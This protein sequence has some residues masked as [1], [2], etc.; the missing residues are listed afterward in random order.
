M[1]DADLY[2]TLL[3]KTLM[4]WP[5]FE[6]ER[7]AARK[8]A[9]TEPLIAKEICKWA[10]CCNSKA[11]ASSQLQQRETMIDPRRMENIRMCLADVVRRNVPGDVIETG[12][13]RGGS[14]IFMR[15][16]LRALSDSSRTVWLA[17]SFC[18]LPKPD[19]ARYPRDEGDVHWNVAGL[20]VPL[21]VVRAN[22]E[23]YGLLDS[24]VKFLAGWFRDTLPNAPIDRLALLRLDGDMYESTIIALRELYPKVSA[25]GY[26][27]IDD[28]PLLPR[29][30]A[31][32]RDYRSDHGINDPMWLIGS[33]GVYWQVSKNEGRL[34]SVPAVHNSNRETKEPDLEFE[35]RT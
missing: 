26:V 34:D 19:V 25:G 30:V 8:L 32:V 21:D 2:L 17:D 10:E 13:W 1:R 12:V 22:F 29:C 4:R 16:V 31:A 27:I 18:G 15:G 23:R 11:G 6:G 5:L 33:R 14:A 28:F 24:Q 20:A 35:G 7:E 9:R 3:R